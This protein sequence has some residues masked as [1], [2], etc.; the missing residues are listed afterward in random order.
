MTEKAQGLLKKLLVQHKN[1]SYIAQQACKRHDGQ[2]SQI[3]C[4][5]QFLERDASEGG[6]DSEC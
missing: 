5:A 1:K 2:N 3:L 4:D 6:N